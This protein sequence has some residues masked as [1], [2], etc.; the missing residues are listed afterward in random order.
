MAANDDGKDRGRMSES[1]FE[2]K[3]V[4]NSSDL[5]GFGVAPDLAGPGFFPRA[6]VVYPSMY[7]GRP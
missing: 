6:G 2:I 3:K 1:E 7:N 5:A 4:Y